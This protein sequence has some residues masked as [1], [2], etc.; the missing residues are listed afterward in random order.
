MQE[1]C[2]VPNHQRPLPDIIN[3]N[4]ANQRTLYQTN[5]ADRY[6]EERATFINATLC[7]FPVYN[8]LS[9]RLAKSQAF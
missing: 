6:S 7:E 5:F 1:E 3:L 8:T 4:A 2:D 9:F